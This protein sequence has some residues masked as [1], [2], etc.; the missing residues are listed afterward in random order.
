MKTVYSIK[1]TEEE[2]RVISNYQRL[3]PEGQ[4]FQDLVSGLVSLIRDAYP[5]IGSLPQGSVLS[6]LDA[7][8]SV[9]SS[10]DSALKA[11]LALLS[12]KAKRGTST[13]IIVP[14]ALSPGAGARSEYDEIISKI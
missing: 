5:G 6:D 12:S 3:A 9:L 2:K 1:L 13:G 10:G 8:R 7:L 11:Q 14:D 4:K